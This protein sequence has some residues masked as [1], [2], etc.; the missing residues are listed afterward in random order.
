MFTWEHKGHNIPSFFKDAIDA[1]SAL[2][3]TAAN[4]KPSTFVIPLF[5]GT[6]YLSMKNYGLSSTQ[7]LE[8]MPLHLLSDEAIYRIVK[9]MCF[10]WLPSDWKSYKPFL[11]SLATLGKLPRGLEYFLEE[12]DREAHRTN[13]PKQL[14]EFENKLQHILLLAVGGLNSRYRFAHGSYAKQ[15]ICDAILGTPVERNDPVHGTALFTKTNGIQ[16]LLEDSNI[17]S[18]S[19]VAG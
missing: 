1:V 12:C 6:S 17:M 5:T 3:C 19:N 7:P 10:E 15:I 2:E 16:V 13:P 14:K 4:S 8:E 18:W 11:R 9:G